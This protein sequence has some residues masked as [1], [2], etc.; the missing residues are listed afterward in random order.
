MGLHNYGLDFSN[1][2]FVL[3]AESYGVKGYRPNSVKEF[4][5]T[6][7]TVINAKGIHL[8]DL[9]VDYSVNHEILNELLKNKTCLV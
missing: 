5:T 1:P 3:H 7:K 9:S 8:I 6:L 2:D 4:V